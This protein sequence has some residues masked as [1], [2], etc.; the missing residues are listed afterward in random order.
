MTW[1]LFIL[2]GSKQ[3]YFN[4]T[5]KHLISTTQWGRSSRSHSVTAWLHVLCAA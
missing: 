2:F 1:H 4:P 3:I 5:S